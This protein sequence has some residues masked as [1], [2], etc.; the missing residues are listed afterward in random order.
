MDVLAQVGVERLGLARELGAQE[1]PGAPFE[2]RGLELEQQRCGEGR[3]ADEHLL[4]LLHVEAVVTQE[5]G[6]R[7]P[8]GF[9]ALRA[10]GSARRDGRG[11]RR[12][13]PRA[14]P[15]PRK[16]SSGR[17]GW[18]SSGSPASS[19]TARR[20]KRRLDAAVPRVLAH[21]HRRPERRV[22]RAGRGGEHAAEHEDVAVGV[23]EGVL[24]CRPEPG[25]GSWPPPAGAA[26]ACPLRRGGRARAGRAASLST[27]FACPAQA[28]AGSIAASLAMDAF[29][30]SVDSLNARWG[31][32]GWPRFPVCGSSV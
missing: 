1:R 8:A 26:S 21:V 13:R 29:A 7:Q 2:D 23:R 16:R 30:D 10:P 12:A 22:L 18:P 9:T 31:T 17:L 6:V 15:T 19:S 25:R 11:A 24:R 28:A 27:G 5:C 3:G 32:P 4:P 20:S 14:L